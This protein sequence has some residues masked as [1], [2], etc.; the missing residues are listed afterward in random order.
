MQ[1]W[2]KLNTDGCCLGNPGICGAG[3]IIRNENGDIVIAFAEKL[4][5]GTNNG[6]ELQ[7]LLYGL[8]HAKRM[9]I[10][11]LEVEL[12]SL[13]IINWLK[14]KVCGIWYLEDYWE[15]IQYLLSTT[16]CRV[17][18]IHREGNSVADILSKMGASSVS[19]I[20]MDSTAIS[21][22]VKGAVLKRL[23]AG[24]KLQVLVS[25]LL[26]V[27][28]DKS[29][30]FNRTSSWQFAIMTLISGGNSCRGRRKN[31]GGQT[32]SSANI[33]IAEVYVWK[34]LNKE[35]KMLK[36]LGNEEAKKEVY[37]ILSPSFG[38]GFGSRI[39]SFFRGFY[40]IHPVAGI[41]PLHHPENY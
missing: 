13:I 12:D 4:D 29:I 32:M 22:S 40:R 23:G 8:R 20:W 41:L 11:R 33:G 24:D 14:R 34:K 15:E 3:G 7:A 35:K 31:I 30:V 9:G 37:D 36:S 18:H 38:S 39:C 21:P 10:T 26:E 5:E 1:G 17:Q 28:K 2:Y 27:L 25:N 19:Q 16:P 6:A